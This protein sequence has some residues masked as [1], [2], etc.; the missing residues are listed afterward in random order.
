MKGPLERGDV[1]SG[2]WPCENAAA[3]EIGAGDWASSV[4]RPTGDEDDGYILIAAMSGQTPMMFI[5]RERRCEFRRLRPGIPIERGHAF[6]SKAATCSDKGGRVTSSRSSRRVRARATARPRRRPS[7]GSMRH[8]SGRPHPSS[9][10]RSVCR[11]EPRLKLPPSD[12]RAR[13]RPIT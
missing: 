11:F 3:R 4:E 9:E 5:T 12:I 8:G 7:S 10:R 1:G 2:S 6:L 13:Q